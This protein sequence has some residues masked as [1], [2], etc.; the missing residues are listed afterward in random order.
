MFGLAA[1]VAVDQ[2][3]RSQFPEAFSEALDLA[4]RQAKS[5]CRLGHRQPAG[6]LI[7]PDSK[8]LALPQGKNY[9][10]GPRTPPFW[11]D[12]YHF[13]PR[14]DISALQLRG[15]IIILP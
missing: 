12:S 9:L 10:P 4:P 3:F 6:I 5:G 7:D 11:R 1:P 14:G 13:S 15:G 8:A 2:S